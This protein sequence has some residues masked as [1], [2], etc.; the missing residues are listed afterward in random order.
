MT[1]LCGGNFVCVKGNKCVFILHHCPGSCLIERLLAFSTL[2]FKSE[3]KKR[4]PD[5]HFSYFWDHAIFN[6]RKF[7]FL[8]SQLCGFSM[9]TRKKA[10]IVKICPLQSAERNCVERKADKINIVNVTCKADVVR[11]SNKV[12]S[13]MINTFSVQFGMCK[14]LNYPYKLMT[15]F[16]I[17][18][19]VQFL[20]GNLAH[21]C[22]VSHF[23]MPRPIRLWI[24]VVIVAV[25]VCTSIQL[26]R[27]AVIVIISTQVEQSIIRVG[28]ICVNGLLTFGLL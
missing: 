22:L 8:Q 20:H 4:T 2:I 13:T 26:V 1:W 27:M 9:P 19:C 21:I 11:Q 25:I 17:W 23:R 14:T 12:Q 16:C 5:T 10:S 18:F 24:V 28:Q 15:K 7:N 6:F 3:G